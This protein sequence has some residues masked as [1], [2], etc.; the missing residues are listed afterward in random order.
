M[1]VLRK[2]KITVKARPSREAGISQEMLMRSGY[3]EEK[4]PNYPTTKRTPAQACGVANDNV[5]AAQRD[6]GE[7]QSCSLRKDQEIPTAARLGMLGS[8]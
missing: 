2:K 3:E 8:T 7:H 4:C 6:C 1:S 5:E